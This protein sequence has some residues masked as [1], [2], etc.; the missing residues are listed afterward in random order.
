MTRPTTILYLAA[1]LALAACQAK[2]DYG[3]SC[4][5]IKPKGAD[6]CELAHSNE[7]LCGVKVTELSSPAFDYLSLGNAECDDQVCLRSASSCAV[8]T[9]CPNDTGPCGADGTCTKQYAAPEDGSAVGYCTRDCQEDTDCE[10]DFRGQKGLLCQKLLFSESY[11]E[12]LKAECETNPNC[13]YND[14]FGGGISEK[15]CVKARPTSN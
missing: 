2:T 15:Y 5:M 9:D 1:L 8:D 14:K 4:K 11:I 12:T 6:P 7:K 10:P 3:Q 13:L